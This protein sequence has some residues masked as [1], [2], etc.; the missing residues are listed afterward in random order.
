MDIANKLFS[1]YMRHRRLKIIDLLFKIYYERK[2]RKWLQ[3][4][5]SKHK[6]RP[7]NI[8]NDVF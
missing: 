4:Y 2:Q 1:F 8:E 5:F 3:K 6:N 7:L